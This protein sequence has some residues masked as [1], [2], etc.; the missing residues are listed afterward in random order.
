[1]IASSV[2]VRFGHLWLALFGGLIAGCTSSSVPQPP[3]IV[4]STEAADS[5]P[6][7]CDVIDRSL[8]EQLVGAGFRCLTVPNFLVNGFF[9]PR[10]NPERSDFNN[11]C[12][13]GDAEAG[14]RLKMSVRPAGSMSMELTTLTAFDSRG[15]LDLG[16]LGPWAPD[17]RGAASAGRTSRVRITLEDAEV[18]VLSSVPEILEQQSAE[19]AA[20]VA[21]R[22]SVQRCLAEFCDADGWVYTAK[23]LAA[24][25]VVEIVMTDGERGGAA[26]ALPAGIAGFE[27]EVIRGQTS[28]L[29]LRATEK[30]NVAALIEPARE[31]FEA[32]GTCQRLRARV[33]RTK[34]VGTVHDI[35]L[36]LTAERDVEAVPAEIRALRAKTVEVDGALTEGERGSWRKLLESLDATAREL[37]R[38][39]PSRSV[40]SAM[41]VL[42]AVLRD[43]SS[44]GE[45]HEVAVDSVQPLLRRLTKLANQHN[46][47]C[48]EPQ[49]YRDAD[50]DGFGDPALSARASTPPRGYVANALDCYDRNAA[51]KPGQKAYFADHRGDGRFDYD[52]DGKV[53]AAHRE[54]SG[55]CQSI[56][57]F[58]IPIRCW[59][60]A[61]WQGQAPDCGAFGRWLAECDKGLFSCEPMAAERRKQLCR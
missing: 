29:R 35:A 42:S 6:R 40:C 1:M 58:T 61:G 54:S 20:G 52:C 23:V 17:V 12:F 60:E 22:N 24:I 43:Q 27:V 39:V 37:G 45:L 32:T 18:R 49:W 59:A 31:A 53:E 38:K 56:T 48:A 14:Q 28:A 10:S 41:D 25:P 21:V 5:V 57:R 8:G 2:M 51:A 36:R 26:L 9:G 19:G 55:G 7:W 46:L 16:F 33:Q 44:T 15:H 11:A 34:L 13:A 3:E 50:E 4:R 47:P 30:L